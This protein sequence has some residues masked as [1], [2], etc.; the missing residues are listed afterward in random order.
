MFGHPGL[1]SLMDS[2]GREMPIT[3]YHSQDFLT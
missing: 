2:Y 3:E 1:N